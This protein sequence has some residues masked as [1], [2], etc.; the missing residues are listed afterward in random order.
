VLLIGIDEAGYGPLLGPLCHGYCAIRWNGAEPMGLA[1]PDLWKILHPSVMRHPAREGSVAVDDS[2]KI[3]A[4]GGGV[5]SLARGVAAF[6][7]CVDESITAENLPALYDTLLPEPDRRALGEEAWGRWEAPVLLES[8]VAISLPKKTRRKKSRT[9]I[10]CLRD[11]LNANAMT[12]AALGARAM[13][14]RLYN[15]ALK[16][17]GNKADVN[18]S[19]IAELLTSL[20]ALAEPGED[21]YAVID[22]Q[23]G[24]KFY[25]GKIADLFPGLMTWVEHETPAK[26]I[27]RIDGNGRTVRVSFL[28]EADGEMLP[29]AVASMAAK[30][31]R[32]F[33]MQRLNQFFR[34][35]LPELKPTAGYYGDAGRFLRD[36]QE[37]RTKL[38]IENAVFVREK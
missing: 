7:K 5:A 15:S 2:K 16:K 38:A 30:L 31:A 27:Y 21:I 9:I 1:P 36:T 11:A 4:Q 34:T 33:C 3:Y 25:T 24:R 35:H 12:V 6:L 28:V 17:S 37:L 14:A 13:S 29:V 8:V 32:E 22:R 19:V 23:G 26:S 18:W 10:P 20:L